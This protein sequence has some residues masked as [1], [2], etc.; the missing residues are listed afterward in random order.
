MSCTGRPV[1]T[2]HTQTFVCLYTH[3]HTHLQYY[4][5]VFGP[6]LKKLWKQKFK[7]VMAL[8]TIRYG[9]KV[10]RNLGGFYRNNET[11]FG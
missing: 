11:K 5:L 7:L 8:P 1:A 9:S 3:T 2:W 10:S 4:Y 6:A